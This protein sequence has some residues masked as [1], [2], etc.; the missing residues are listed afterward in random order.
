MPNS[1][2]ISYRRSDSQHAAFAIADRMRWSFGTEEIF[3]D[4]GSIEGGDSWPQS[5]QKA[6]ASAKL[7]LVIIGPTWLST[8]DKWGRRRIDDPEDWVQREICTALS[9]NAAGRNTIVQVCL[10]GSEELQADALPE[11]LR[12][13]CSLH[14]KT[15]HNDHWEGG[16][17]ALL[18]LVKSKTGLRRIRREM[19]EDKNSD[20]PRRIARPDPKESGRPVMSVE[21]IHAQLASF[22]GWDLNWGPH[23]WGIAGQA[24]EISK[25]YEFVSFPEAVGFMA[26]TASHIQAWKPP[27][28]PRWENQWRSL[29]AFFTTWDV[30]CRVTKLDIKAAKD[31][32]ALYFKFIGGEATKS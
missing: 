32:D 15:L 14:K 17:E 30:G 6:L 21:K 27:H 2:F 11:P 24:Q 8:A 5:I 3:F 9:A 12:A 22:T 16:I 29:T 26:Y 23:P 20:D 18:K 28:H 31:L 10:E 19:E 7:V 4:R 25:T 1:V 13:L